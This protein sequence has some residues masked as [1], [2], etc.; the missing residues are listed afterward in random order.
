MKIN[1]FIKIILLSLL[2]INTFAETFVV[3][4]IKVFG[5]QKVD[6]GILLSSLPFEQGG[7]FDT[8]DTNSYIKAIYKTG[9]FKTID[10]SR[11]K[12]SVLIHV[13]EKP[14]IAKIKLIGNESFE[15]EKLNKALEDI[16]IKEG[17][18][19]DEF[20]LERLIK[21]LEQQYLG[22]GKY[23]VN[24][25][26]NVEALDRNRVAIEINI[27]EGKVALIKQ[28]RIIGNNS[29]SQA[30]LLENFTL[31]EGSMLSWVTFSDRYSKQKLSGDLEKLKSFYLDKGYLN[32][33]IDDARISLSPDKKNVYITIEINEGNVFRVGNVVIGGRSQDIKEKINK[34]ITV[35]KNE[36]YS[37]SK[38][39]AIEND[40]LA[41]LGKSGYMYAKVNINKGVNNDSKIVNLTFFIN[42]GK[43]VYVRRIIFQGNTRTQDQV[44]R[45]EM[46]QMEGGYVSREKIDLSKLRLSQLG[47]IKD[48]NVET[49]PVSGSDDQVDL[50]YTLTEASTGHFSGG[51]GYQEKEGFML[52][53]GLSQENFLGTG[54]SLSSNFNKSKAATNAN[55]AYFD[56]YFTIDGIGL[57]YNLFYSKTKTRELAV[58]DYKL[59]V[60]GFDLSLRIPVSLF[61]LISFSGGAQRKE[62]L[63]SDNSPDNVKSF[64][65][66]HG[67]IYNQYPIGA[68]WSHSKL[69]R[70]LFPTSGWKNQLSA[71]I[72]VPGSTLNYFM[73]YNSSKLFVPLYDQFILYLKGDI[74]YGSGYN[75]DSSLPFFENYYA[76][77][78]G[79]V[80][81][82]EQNSLGPRSDGREGVVLGGNTKLAGTV[83]MFLP[84]LFLTNVAWRPSVFVDAGNV[85][86]SSIKLDKLRASAGA[87]VQWLSPMGP[88]SISYAV[89][90]REFSGDQPKGFNIN[91]GS[92]F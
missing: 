45:R 30:E 86:D 70:A 5:L 27:S 29:F 90:I 72:M 16:G 78:V 21:E 87:G 44:L 41:E 15:E 40:I 52:N 88:L 19:F 43:R 36:I 92:I 10:I 59:N 11:D 77:G 17:G 79:T 22:Q 23:A 20:T 42:P 48:I 82:F 54:K 51:V 50:I 64:V 80:R 26:T 76:G 13:K 73:I 37:E 75:S 31:T 12:N 8:N 58:A 81:G 35:T 85:Y 71:S 14:A 39:S 55:L 68:A 1:T 61:D 24:I 3:K 62:I 53:L 38:L 33:K 57:G 47:Y 9:Y 69:D 2:C 91:M 67:K 18:T 25:N 74:G 65:T 60:Y 83:E 84:K 49:V 4:D 34:Y 56:P 89:P 28:I 6:E 46:L 7:T 66:K 63:S 32:F